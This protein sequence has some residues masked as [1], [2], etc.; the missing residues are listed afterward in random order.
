MT[1]YYYDTRYNEVCETINP[2]L[3]PE[4]YFEMGV[5]LGDYYVDTYLIDNNKEFNFAYITIDSW[6]ENYSHWYALLKSRCEGIGVDINTIV[7]KRR[8][9]PKQELIDILKEHGYKYE[10]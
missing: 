6:K 3:P 8:R 1:K 4:A 9:Y 10:E 2:N 7:L 5:T